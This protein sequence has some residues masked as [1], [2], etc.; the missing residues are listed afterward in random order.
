MVVPDVRQNGVG[1]QE[2][3]IVASH[4]GVPDVGRTDG[5]H[6]GLLDVDVWMLG[7]LLHLGRALG[8]PHRQPRV[9]QQAVLIKHRRVAF[10]GGKG[11]QIVLAHDD[12]ESRVKILKYEKNFYLWWK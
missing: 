5:D 2:L 4:D 3:D 12:A 7:P 8:L 9:D 6:R 11:R 10:P 1:K